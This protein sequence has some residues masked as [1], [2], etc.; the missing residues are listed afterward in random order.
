MKKYFLVLV[1]LIFCGN[2]LSANTWTYVRSSGRPLFNS[3]QKLFTIDVNMCVSVDGTQWT[4]LPNNYSGL[5]LRIFFTDQNTGYLYSGIGGPHY[6][7]SWF[8]KT[9]DGGLSWQ[10]KYYNPSAP[11]MAMADHVLCGINGV[12]YIVGGQGIKASYDDG[13]TWIDDYIM[14]FGEYTLRLTHTDNAL[15]AGTLSVDSL[16]VIK[17]SGAEWTTIL[18]LTA[19]APNNNRWIGVQA[20]PNEDIVYAVSRNKVARICGNDIT[21]TVLDESI[22]LW[23]VAFLNKQEGYAIGAQYGAD[24]IVL[25]T[26]DGGMTWNHEADFSEGTCREITVNNGFLYISVQNDH[27]Y[28]GAGPFA[29]YRA[30]LASTGTGNSTQVI[31][32]YRLMQNYPNPFNPTTSIRYSLPMNSAVTLTVFNS[33]GKEVGILVN[34]KQVAGDYEVNFNATNLSSG[35]YFYRLEAEGFSETK[36]MLLIK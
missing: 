11:L 32:N 30:P 7:Y 3:G 2:S 4:T 8:L 20:V 1:L 25:K 34:Q 35:I 28:W 23:D 26:L 29:I 5:P 19:E 36:K 14:P 9:T 17:K 31:D 24:G 16:R 18:T 12:L 10:Q 15:Y 13:V 33:L 21:T 6:N 27:P 22:T